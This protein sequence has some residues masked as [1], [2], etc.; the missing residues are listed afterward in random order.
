MEV[1][2]LKQLSA[3]LLLLFTLLHEDSRRPGCQV[4]MYLSGTQRALSCL[5]DLLFSAALD[6]HPDVTLAHEQASLQAISF[7][8]F[9]WLRMLCTQVSSR[10]ILACPSALAAC[11]Q[12]CRIYSHP[13]K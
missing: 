1:F 2:F 11:V 12:L 3:L 10:Q 9:R 4:P 5:L 13:G 7:S 8:V 6:R